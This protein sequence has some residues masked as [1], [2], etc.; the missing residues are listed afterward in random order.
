[1][2]HKPLHLVCGCVVVALFSAPVGG[3]LKQQGLCKLEVG[4]PR[5]RRLCFWLK[6]VT[7][8]RLSQCL[9]DLDAVSWASINFGLCWI[10]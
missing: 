9:A 8:I 2:V 6:R 4:G 3:G 10:C 1:M 5:F 7:L